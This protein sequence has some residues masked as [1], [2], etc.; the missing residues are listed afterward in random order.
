[1]DTGPHSLV[2]G[3]YT[4]RV[5]HLNGHA[6]GILAATYNSADLTEVTVAAQ[7]RNPSWLTATADGRCLYA[8]IEAADFQGARGGG[9]A[10]YAR[11]PGTGALTLL[12]AAPS[13]GADP[14]HVELDVA[15]RYVVVAN[16]STGSVTVFRRENDGRLGKLTAHIRHKGSSIHA[17]RQASPHPHQIL[18]DPV[19]GDML[20]PDLGLDAVLCYRLGRDGALTERPEACISVTPGAGPRHAAFHPDNRHLFLLNELNNTLVVLRRDSGSFVPVDVAST[21]PGDFAGRSQASAVR[22]SVTG[23]SVLVSNRGSNSIAVFAFDPAAGTVTLRAVVPTRGQEPR[24]FI[25]T[26]DGDHVL[27]GNAQSDT[28][29]LF[30]FDEEAAALKFI[31]AADVPSPVCLRFLP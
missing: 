30:A 22:V 4:E 2:I 25:L 21:L 13:V 20:V 26:P 23:Q 9:I 11:D 5:P 7:L 8:V 31:S 19:T 15:E 14:A 16:Y 3:T 24:D 17:T 10:A 6:A 12:N 1:M 27:V 29:V 18:F 28:A